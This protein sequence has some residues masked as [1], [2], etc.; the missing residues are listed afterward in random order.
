MGLNE[1]NWEEFT[2]KKK[3]KKKFRILLEN[4]FEKMLDDVRLKTSV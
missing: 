2:R 3:N 1:H 4:I